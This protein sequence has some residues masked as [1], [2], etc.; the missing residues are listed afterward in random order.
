MIDYSFH[1][2]GKFSGHNA[3]AAAVP[4]LTTLSLFLPDIVALHP[5][6]AFCV[7]FMSHKLSCVPKIADYDTQYRLQ[8]IFLGILDRRPIC[9]P[10]M[11]H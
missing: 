8:A 10:S 1:Q 11:S 7:S 9:E 5:Q 3:L 2:A 4:D 6:T